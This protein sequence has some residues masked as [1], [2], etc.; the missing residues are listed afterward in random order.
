MYKNK[1]DLSEGH[2]GGSGSARCNLDKKKP[3]FRGVLNF[4]HSF[5]SFSAFT[6]NSEHGL[7]N[8]PYLANPNALP[9]K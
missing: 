9:N 1:W 5:R 3:P 7:Q 8:T 2:P 4:Y 6:A